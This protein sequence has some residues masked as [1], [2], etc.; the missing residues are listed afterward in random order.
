MS[1]LHKIALGFTVILLVVGFGLGTLGLWNIPAYEKV[2]EALHPLIK[3]G[4]V[5]MCIASVIGFLTACC[6]MIHDIWND[7]IKGRKKKCAPPV[8][9]VSKFLTA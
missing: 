2:R 4:G 8:S 1:K 6:V 9:S 7:D 3:V 5:I